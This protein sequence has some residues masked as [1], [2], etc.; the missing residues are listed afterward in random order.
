MSRD[1][2]V[3]RFVRD[4]IRGLTSSSA[5][6][7]TV[8]KLRQDY[9][10]RH[11]LKAGDRF[12]N[13]ETAEEVA[14]TLAKRRGRDVNL[15]LAD[16]HQ[17]PWLAET[18]NEES[19]RLFY[20]LVH[21]APSLLTPQD[22]ALLQ[23]EDH[24]RAVEDKLAER[25]RA[26][27]QA[28]VEAQRQQLE[29]ERQLLLEEKAELDKYKSHLH[30]IPLETTLAQLREDLEAHQPEESVRSTRV[31]WKEAGLAEDP[32]PSNRGL[33]GFNAEKYD[34]VV[35]RTPLHDF[36]L[37]A[38]KTDP[39]RL[40][41]K[42][43]VV[44]GE[45]GS[46]KTTLFQYAAATAGHAGILPALVF[47]APHPSVSSLVT[48]ML[49]RLDAILAETH[50]ARGAVDP[51]RFA[52]GE[53]LE[54]AVAERLLTL[55]ESGIRGFLVFI[56]GLHKGTAYTE[57]V[58][59]FLQQ[60]Q[61]IQEYLEASN[62]LVGFIVAGS[63]YW[64]REL[65]NRPSLS[66]SVYRRDKLPD[67]TEDQAVEA[68]ERRI[69][70]F[71]P[72]DSPPIRLRRDSLRQAY[73]ALAH[74]LRRPVT[75][76]D[77][78]DHI[79]G[80]LE[81]GAY[82][83]A[84]LTVAL[85]VETV[86]AV[87]GFFATSSIGGQYRDLWRELA[88]EATL[89]RACQRTIGLI[90]SAGG[91]AESHPLFRQLRG[92]FY[93]LYKYELIVQRAAEDAAFKWHLSPPLVAV[94]NDAAQRLKVEPEAVLRA[95]FEEESNLRSTEAKTIYATTIALLSESSSSWRDAWEP[96]SQRLDSAHAALI[97][98]DRCVEAGK[99]ET[100]EPALLSRSLRGLVVAVNYV[101]YANEP[102][103]D[104][105]WTAFE[106]A[107]AAPENVEA[108]KHMGTLDALPHG[109]TAV[110]GQLHEHS[111]RVQQLLHVLQELVLGESICRLRGRKL[112][113]ETLDA[114][115]ELRISFLHQNFQNV[116][117]GCS[118]LLERRI[119][120]T[121]YPALRA[122]WGDKAISRIPKDVQEA[123]AKVPQRGHPRAKREAD[124]N[125]L[126]DVSRS[127]YSKIIFEG[128]VAKALFGEHVDAGSRERI[129][130][131]IEL[132]FSMNDRL[133]HRDRGSYFREKAT[134]VGD[135][136]KGLPRTLEV[137]Q[138]ISTRFACDGEFVFERDSDGSYRG[139]FNPSFLPATATHRISKKE[140]LA[141]SKA[142]L[143]AA[144]AKDIHVEN[145]TSPLV[146]GSVP[147]ELQLLILRVLLRYKFLAVAESPD[148]PAVIA[149]TEAGRRELRTFAHPATQQKFDDA[150]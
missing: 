45:F 101:I 132:S 21:P 11:K 44:I 27:A 19:L 102:T 40:F 91:V 48:T 124:S 149:L 114:L 30:E 49:Q 46:G 20:D 56:D 15:F 17:I 2:V 22:L 97:A 75:F 90:L 121:V 112:S 63:P 3:S 59:D 115:H 118:E 136:L 64:E 79:R 70:A 125:F 84:G 119:R 95:A 139:Q 13:Q 72:Q 104:A 133:A 147:P 4:H 34:A 122:L 71:T 82:E 150:L 32:F 50:A 6:L 107:W 60:I 51:R 78:L 47:I 144:A 25:A 142:I 66:G 10:D 1:A 7:Q 134:E 145:L 143:D 12:S 100:L 67:L 33:T 94:T 138:A 99:L 128:T 113:A 76:R 57:Q 108:I 105:I 148:G 87:H 52:Q 62:V 41:G 38:V 61:T 109:Q 37:E 55:Q 24:V 74:R 18:L 135:I 36:Y 111:Q 127:Q 123:I 126:Y 120:E 5:T 65:I 8:K 131:H 69:R 35:V 110:L 54:K 53:D 116:V 77:F 141:V 92:G 28:E 85:H 16:C 83:E 9:F 31:W 58:F 39:E 42:T 140:G 88:A 43:I 117:A 23:K 68:V 96:V 98:I 73:R 89:R 86:N 93:L 106:R 130:D 137:L 26:D 14:K 80:R 81:A 29:G 103:E 146:A 129:R